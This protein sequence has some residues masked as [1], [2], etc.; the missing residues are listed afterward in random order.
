MM[1]HATAVRSERFRLRL[2]LSAILLTFVIV[3]AVWF[4]GTLSGTTPP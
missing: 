4:L 2:L 3:V 1:R